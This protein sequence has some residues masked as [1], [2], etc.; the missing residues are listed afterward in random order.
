MELS[1]QYLTIFLGTAFL[2]G[3]AFY[4]YNYDKARANGKSKAQAA[5]E[6]EQALAISTERLQQ[7]SNVKDLIT[8]PHP[9]Q[10]GLVSHIARY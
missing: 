2:F 8:K 5:K 6:A 7:A 1:V 9:N 3:G 10:S 4:R